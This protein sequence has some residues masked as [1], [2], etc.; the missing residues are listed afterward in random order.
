MSIGN[1]VALGRS[2]RSV[3]SLLAAAG[4]AG[5]LLSA[6]GVAFGQAAVHG[7]VA[8][9]P[10]AASQMA[11]VVDL[12]AA[13]KIVA[14][15][16]ILTD[17]TTRESGIA[18]TDS[19]RAKAFTLLSNA[20]RRLKSMAPTEVS[21]QTAEE[22][23]AKGDY[24]TLEKH[25]NAVIAA[26]KATNEQSATAR[27]LLEKAAAA[28]AG[29]T[30]KVAATLDRINADYEAGRVKEAKAALDSL[31]RSGVVLSP[32][33]EKMVTSL[34]TL[35]VETEQ[36]KAG[37]I[38]AAP[39]MFQP[40]VIK[41]RNPQPAPKPAEPPAQPPAAEA[42][43]QPAPA[44]Q[45]PAQPAAEQPAQPAPAAQPPAQPPADPIADAMKWDALS[46]LAEADQAFDKAQY[47]EAVKKY[48]HVLGARADMLTADQKAHAEKNLAEA[49]VRMGSNV[50]V[51]GK[52]L[53]NYVRDTKLRKEESLAQYSNNMEQ[54]KAALD[55]GNTGAARDKAAAARL[56]VTS[57]RELFSATELEDYGHQ[58]DELQTAIDRRQAEIET[59]EKIKKAEEIKKAA[60]TQ[61]MTAAQTKAR[62][63]TEAFERVRALQ[64]ELKYEEAIQVLDQILFLD[65]INPTALMLRDTLSDT[66]MYRRA[67]TTI[68]TQRGSYARQSL[69]NIEA[70]IA[71]DYLV[72]YPADWP[73]ISNIRGQ[74]TAFQEP[75]ENRNAYAVLESKTVP[76]D[77]KDA[78]LESIVGF[79]AA[80]TNLNVDAD[81][82]KLQEAGID[83]DATVSLRLT[84]VPVKTIL[85]RVLEKV[86]KDSSNG[87]AYAINGGVVT[88]STREAI[89]RTK[90]IQIYDIKDLLIEVPNYDN[91]PQFDLQSV[92]Q[93]AGQGG[94]G[95]QSPFRE[96][97]NQNDKGSGR[98]T[99]EERTNELINI[100][101]TNVDP[102]GWQEN[103]GDV[104]FIQQLQGSMIITN[105]PANHRAINGLLNKL[106]EIRAM[107]I[108]VETRFLLVSTKFFEQIGFDLDVYFNGNNNQVRAARAAIPNGGVQPSDFFDFAQGGLQRRVF[109]AP[110]DANGDG[111]ADPQ[112]GVAVVNPSPLSV[113]GAGQNSL[114]LTEAG[115]SGSFAQGILSRAPAL[116]VAGQFMD[117]VQVD[118]LVKATQADVR[119]I[120]LTAP[121]LTFTNGQ[122]S[123]IYVATQVAFVSD[124]TPVVSE[125]AV[126]F[127]P[128]LATVN[129]GVVLLVEGT[130]SADRRYVTLNVDAAV[131]K[132]DGFQ[133]TAVSAVTGGGIVNSAATQSFIQLPTTTVTRVRTTVTV[134]DQGTILLGG[135][136]LIAEQEIESGV[137][138]LSKIPILNRFFSNRIEVKEEQT[139]LILIKPTILIQ[140]E[141]EQRN[142]PGLDES[143]KFPG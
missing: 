135:Q 48:E 45:P 93:S 81:W 98:R 118:F 12:L 3:G 142:F 28:K 44:A 32:D 59:T 71:P 39:G 25:A 5:G 34:Q 104:G 22:C 37:H 1:S 51:E 14:A 106:R 116:G 112:V 123:N 58:V 138:V 43:A 129:E 128:T 141:E 86:S 6:P 136:R 70:L 107:Q 29:L 119:S 2:V 92:L 73:S 109:G 53:D 36:V 9:T 99:I 20:N 47:N 101:T 7:E 52:I 61:A 72:K 76:V 134:P 56:N 16:S 31:N 85:D 88:I 17:L 126:G 38:A 79:I 80:V 55:S 108:N 133:N 19:E 96:T 122:T 26:P 8:S 50:G 82:E 35:I 94:G 100:L 23:L 125:A 105:T 74:P 87:A 120:Q 137:P 46:I 127:D 121:R 75:E 83:R 78:T 143:L 117:D 11:E 54:A 115:A 113:I 24:V 102:Q 30:P 4:L 57:A 63:I 68:E 69:D 130:I 77:F 10:T 84:K 21:L 132:I 139:L 90:S 124:L 62:K 49:K 66:I 89:N 67:M 131:S 140:N 33:Q 65:P 41:P 103:G 95:N 40:G 111:Q 110:T 114:G 64:M 97:G 15:K 13:G 91:A 60:E 42:P 27:E 18:M